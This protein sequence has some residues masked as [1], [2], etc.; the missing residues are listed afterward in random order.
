AASISE[1]KATPT[2]TT[3]PSSS[4]TTSTFPSTS[5]PSLPPSLAKSAFQS[6][7]S[8]LQW[9][10]SPSPS[11]LPQWSC[12]VESNLF[13]KTPLMSPR[14]PSS[15]LTS[16]FSPPIRS[17]FPLTP[18]LSMSLIIPSFLASASLSLA[19]LIPNSSTKRKERRRRK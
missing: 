11:W 15:D 3:T 16:L 17:S 9:T 1:T 19:P 14:P 8:H 5:C 10:Q 18:E 13:T 6:L 12:S 4:L 2:I 7:G